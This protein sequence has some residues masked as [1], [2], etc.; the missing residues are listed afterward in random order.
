MCAWMEVA[1]SGSPADVA[2][3]NHSP[4]WVPRIK[5]PKAGKPQRIGLL[6][7]LFRSSL[8]PSASVTVP[9][10]SLGVNW[11]RLS[12]DEPSK[13]LGKFVLQVHSRPSK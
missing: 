5:P 13:W 12:V 6:S 7:L 11:K 1:V 9:S 3:T 2:C 10:G 4:S 8:M